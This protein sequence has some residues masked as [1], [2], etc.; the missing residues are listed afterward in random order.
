MSLSSLRH[1]SFDIFRV[2][3]E[4]QQPKMRI[5]K[6]RSG[7]EATLARDLH[8]LAH[9]QIFFSSID[10]LNDPHEYAHEV[11]KETYQFSDL[12]SYADHS[13]SITSLRK[14]L[15]G[16]I[17]KSRKWGVWSAS[18]TYSHELLWAY[19]ADSHKGFCIEYDSKILVRSL[20]KKK[21]IRYSKVK[22]KPTVPIIVPQDLFS[23]LT[24]DR[25][26][27]E[28]FIGTKSKKWAHEREIRVVALNCGSY[29]IDKNAIKAIYFGCRADQDTIDYAKDIMA[30]N[31][32]RIDYYR[33]YPKKGHYEFVRSPI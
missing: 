32:F 6:Y 3:N 9:S 12:M 8:T 14:E 33:I 22:Y 13:G 2:R 24:V 25:N 27:T 30:A 29:H 23:V 15:D 28:K 5:F 16:F 4:L 20:P 31:N 17:A 19:Y 7:N 26:L 1:A 10:G 21:I 11:M 18:I